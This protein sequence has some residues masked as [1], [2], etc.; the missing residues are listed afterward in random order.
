M[1]QFGGREIIEMKEDIESSSRG[2]RLEH[3]EI[4]FL[5]IFTLVLTLRFMFR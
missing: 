3:Y 2:T 5:N 4:R 1:L